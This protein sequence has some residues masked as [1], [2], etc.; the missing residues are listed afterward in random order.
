MLQQLVLMP[1]FLS[2][3]A[4]GRTEDENVPLAIALTEF[5][6]ILVYKRMFHA[7]CLLNS[8]QVLRRF[9]LFCSK[10]GCLTV[11]EVSVCALMT[12][13]SGLREVGFDGVIVLL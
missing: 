5:H 4:D 13:G 3:F 1:L 12:C 11:Y 2:S 9:F 8:K 10:Y 7:V 6:V